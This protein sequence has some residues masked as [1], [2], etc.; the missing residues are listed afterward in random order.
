MTTIFNAL[1]MI[2]LFSYF[3]KDPMYNKQGK[4]S[5]W[6]INQYIEKNQESIIK[7]YE[8]MVDTIYDVYIFTENLSETSD[9]KDLGNFYYPDYIIITNEENYVAYEFKDLSKFKQKTLNY[10]DRTVKAVIFHELTHALVN[11]IY[12]TMV[13]PSP[14]YGM[15]R[16]YPQYG[17]QFGSAF[18]EEGI[19]EYVVYHLNE[20]PSL[21]NIPVP[22]N[23]DDLIDPKNKVNNVYYYSVVFLK[24]F[25]DEQGIEKGIE[26][27]IG[28]KPPSYDEI[29]NPSSYFN[30][31]NNNERKN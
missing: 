30:R 9:P 14:E 12:L 6:G 27:L 29:L 13:N 4:P 2:I 8:Y 7:E 18:I 10:T 5:K 21:K 22:E 28:N 15:I 24:D 25:L 20:S 11:Q 23:T 1:W 16:I 31:L 19:C 26:I 3:Q 17:N